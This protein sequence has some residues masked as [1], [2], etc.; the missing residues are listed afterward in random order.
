MLESIKEVWE[1]ARI[2]EGKM[3]E[4]WNEGGPEKEMKDGSKTT[5]AAGITNKA[6]SFKVKAFPAPLS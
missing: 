6:R 1:G 3:G 2:I 5:G 4:D